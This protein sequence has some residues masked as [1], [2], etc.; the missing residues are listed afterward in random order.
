MQEQVEN[1]WFRE[2]VVL[3]WGEKMDF[4]VLFLSSFLFKLPLGHENRMFSS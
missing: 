1:K 2:E 3:I 4:L